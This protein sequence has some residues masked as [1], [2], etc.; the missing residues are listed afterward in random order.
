MRK[1]T[2]GGKPGCG[3]RDLQKSR[4]R[5]RRELLERFLSGEL[6]E[7]GYRAELSAWGKGELA[8]WNPLEEKT[9]FGRWDLP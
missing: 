7:K 2:V 9:G 6:E 3:E 8:D 4:G 1:K 5:G